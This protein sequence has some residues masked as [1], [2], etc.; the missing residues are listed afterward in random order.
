M[1]SASVKKLKQKR[2]EFK[3][4]MTEL[5]NMNP[6]NIVIDIDK[7]NSSSDSSNYEDQTLPNIYI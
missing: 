2:D 5:M 7:M 3:L 4:K 1:S 6:I